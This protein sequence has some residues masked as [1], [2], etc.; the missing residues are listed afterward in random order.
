MTP[1]FDLLEI[2]VSRRYAAKERAWAIGQCQA[3][4]GTERAFI[5]ALVDLRIADDDVE[6][7][8]QLIRTWAY[9]P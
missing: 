7:T 5:R 8:I 1:P 9:G 2:A 6:R 4:V 3:S